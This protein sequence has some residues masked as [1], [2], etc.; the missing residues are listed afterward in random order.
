[1][2][3]V[4]K[5]GGLLAIHM[6]DEMAME[7][8]VQN[9][10]MMNRPGKRH[11]KLKNGVNRARLDDRSEGVGEVNSSA[12]PEAANHPT[13]LITRQGTVGVE[14]VAEYPLASYHIDTCRLRNQRASQI[15]K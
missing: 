3:D 10:Q 11:R 4:D 2:I 1:M 7:E 5:A 14:L 12:L 8:R 15:L 6:F 9:I 13:G